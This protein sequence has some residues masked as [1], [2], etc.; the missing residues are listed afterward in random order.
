MSAAL[1]VLTAL[2][3]PDLLRIKGIVHVA[4]EPGPMSTSVPD[5]HYLKG[6]AL[7]NLK[8]LDRARESYDAVIKNYPDSNAAALAKQRIAKP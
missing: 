6:E 8:Q 5:S 7:R 3:G 2:R 1:D 4:G